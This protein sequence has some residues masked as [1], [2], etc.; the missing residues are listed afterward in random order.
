LKALTNA[1]RIEKYAHLC[2]NP[3]MNM[4][5]KIG[6]GIAAVAGIGILVK[7]FRDYRKITAPTGAAERAIND[8]E[9]KTAREKAN[10]TQ[11]RLRDK[12][13]IKPLT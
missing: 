1:S 7:A 6:F 4:D 12:G 10:A 13:L 2:I 8:P 5:D 3:G 11:Q 9:Y